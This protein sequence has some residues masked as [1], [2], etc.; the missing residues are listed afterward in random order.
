MSL[1]LLWV[2]KQYRLY[3]RK[4]LPMIGRPVNIYWPFFKNYVRIRAPYD[5]SYF[6]ALRYVHTVSVRFG[7]SIHFSIRVS[8]RVRRS[9]H[10][11]QFYSD[12]PSVFLPVSFILGAKI[13]AFSCAGAHGKFLAAGVRQFK[14]FS[15]ILSKDLLILCYVTRWFWSVWWV[16]LQSM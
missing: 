6:W 8:F 2:K 11:H 13:L 9:V 5:R 10:T 1:N 14:A 12:E 15:Q 7:I 3:I 4:S 16:N